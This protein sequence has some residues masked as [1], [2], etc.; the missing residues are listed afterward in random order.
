MT[1]Y[2]YYETIAGTKYEQNFTV[3][4]DFA[5]ALDAAMENQYVNLPTIKFWTKP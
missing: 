4:F 3:L 2:L 5:K 1:Y